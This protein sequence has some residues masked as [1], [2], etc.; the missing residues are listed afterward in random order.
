LGEGLVLDES[1]SFDGRYDGT[2]DIDIEAL[3][4]ISFLDGCGQSSENVVF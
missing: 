2:K 4:T 3:L 1:Q